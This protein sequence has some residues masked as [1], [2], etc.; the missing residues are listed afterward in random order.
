MAEINIASL[1]LEIGKSNPQQNV[2][3]QTNVPDM[4]FN[5]ILSSFDISSQPQIVSHSETEG[6]LK[7]SEDLGY[8]V[9]LA[10]NIS[11]VTTQIPQF[12]EP[13]QEDV[14]QE[15]AQLPFGSAEIEQYIPTT[16]EQIVPI[17]KINNK[18]QQ[19]VMEERQVDIG[20]EDVISQK[21]IE[22]ESYREIDR[23][24]EQ[25]NS[26]DPGIA[27]LFPTILQNQ[28]YKEGQSQNPR[29]QALEAL[30]SRDA[31][32]SHQQTEF[33]ELVIE[34]DTLKISN[35]DAATQQTNLEVKEE[36][37]EDIL[38]ENN[39]ASKLKSDIQKTYEQNIT[40]VTTTKAPISIE[41][42]HIEIERA[43]KTGES[44]IKIAL[45]P[46]S[47]GVIDVKINI[48][49]NG[50]YSF[51]IIAENKDTLELLLQD[52]K[53][54]ELQIKEVTK[55]EDSSFSFNL[56]DENSHHQHKK[57]TQSEIL[58]LKTDE[59]QN[60]EQYS[61]NYAYGFYNKSSIMGGIDISV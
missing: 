8:D 48:A 60:K 18:P 41:H 23:E 24:E 32:T 42:V 51:E 31:I 2:L 44:E 30:N 5:E 4:N 45:N 40:K 55:S 61:A 58:E 6:D 39:F 11:E 13:L 43:I 25:F 47:L 36:V 19:L 50:S 34:K 54:L 9:S 33:S 29:P 14:M 3:N 38:P 20:F 53:N 21:L 22:E 49:E 17:T 28:S 56:K 16:I 59:H 46:E 52:T 35:R 27:S 37:V 57:Q 26:E 1:S 7:I 12:I 15:I 10:K